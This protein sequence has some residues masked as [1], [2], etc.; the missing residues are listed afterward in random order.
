MHDA[1]R[2]EKV[3]ITQLVCF[4]AE[5]LDFDPA[6]VN[7]GFKAIVQTPNTQAKFFSQLTLRDVG[8]VVQDAHD[9]EVGVFLLVGLAAGH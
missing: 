5:A 9:P 4:A 1:C 8:A 2:S 3:G 6:F 7:Q